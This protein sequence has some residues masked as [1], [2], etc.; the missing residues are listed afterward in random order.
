[1]VVLWRDGR[2]AGSSR[3][4][5]WFQPNSDVRLAST[6]LREALQRAEA[7]RQGKVGGEEIGLKP[8]GEGERRWLA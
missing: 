1:M 5:D 7:E 6:E 8:T 4:S 3:G 2:V